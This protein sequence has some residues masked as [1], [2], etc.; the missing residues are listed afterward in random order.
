MNKNT[1]NTILDGWLDFALRESI[2][3]TTLD[4]PSINEFLTVKFEGLSESEDEVLLKLRKESTSLLKKEFKKQ[5]EGASAE[6][7]LFFP[8]IQ[9]VVNNQKVG[10]PL[11]AYKLNTQ[12]E[13]MIDNGSI[14]F[15]PFE[16]TDIHIMKDIFQNELNLPEEE[17][18]AE[19]N[20]L[21]FMNSLSGSN[22]LT[23]EN[24][25]ENF[26]EYI[27]GLTRFKI[28][29][30]AI[31]HEG[32]ITYEYS[33]FSK[34]VKLIRETGLDFSPLSKAYLTA[35]PEVKLNEKIKH[36]YGSFNNEYPLG[37]GQ[38]KVLTAKREN[39]VVPV[40]GAPGTGK[41]T[42]I[43]SV[44]AEHITK[45]AI[46]LLSNSDRD[47]VD[48]S[49]LIM[50]LSSANKAVENIEEGLSNDPFLK[51]RVDF[52]LFLGN[53]EKMSIASIKIDAFLESFERKHFNAQRMKVL[54]REIEELVD[55]MD[56][57][58]IKTKEF[59]KYV[60]EKKEM[61][62]RKEVLGI[63]LR[64]VKIGI[65]ELTV[66]GE[67]KEMDLD[68]LSG[69]VQKME[70]VNQLNTKAI[71]EV[72]S[73]K[74]HL[75][76]ISILSDKI[77]RKIEDLESLP[78]YVRYEGFSEE[79]MSNELSNIEKRK[80]LSIEM[81]NTP[82][83][84]WAIDGSN[85]IH[86]SLT[87][88]IEKVQDI[89]MYKLEFIFKTRNKLLNNFFLKNEKFLTKIGFTRNMFSEERLFDIK[90]FFFKIAELKDDGIY[91]IVDQSDNQED[92]NMARKIFQVV[93]ELSKMEKAL[94]VNQNKI[95]RC[96]QLVKKV[97][98]DSKK[99]GVD[100]RHLDEAKLLM[101]NIVKLQNI[102][103]EL[104]AIEG[105]L[106]E[107]Q[108]RTE[109]S[110]Q[111][112][113]GDIFEVCRKH[114]IKENR[115]LFELSIEYLEQIQLKNKYEVI[116]ALKSFQKIIN[117]NLN[118]AGAVRSEWNGRVSRLYELVSLAFP[119]LTSTVASFSK[120]TSTFHSGFFN[121]I[122][123][124]VSWN[125]YEEPPISLMLS[126]ESGMTKVHSL[127][128]PVYYSKQAIIVGDENQLEP[129]VTISEQEIQENIF[130]FFGSDRMDSMYSPGYVSAYGRSAGQTSSINKLSRG[131]LLDEHRR[132]Q[133]NIANIFKDIVQGSYYDLK[134]QTPVLSGDR[135]AKF[136]GF[137]SQNNIIY[138]VQGQ[139][140]ISNVNRLEV[141]AVDSVLN[142]LEVAGYDLKKDV[143]IITPYKGQAKELM[144]RYKNRVNHSSAPGGTKKIG[145][146]HSFQGVEFEVIIISTV[147]AGDKSA[148]FINGK[149]SL[150]NVSVSRAKDVLIVIGDVAKL[151]ASGGNTA[152]LM[153]K[154]KTNGKMRS[155]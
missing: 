42:L 36:W 7:Y 22:N 154:M 31:I 133:P 149:K 58:Y 69:I 145:T 78:N 114:H 105:P 119:V 18:P 16:G 107:L 139:V 65:E 98:E 113:N 8:I 70:K 34:Q 140:T 96:D 23:F 131:I 75:K 84:K 54:H 26:C 40:E 21:D 48:E 77:E 111:Y 141:N 90:A 2:S 94:K 134:V 85:D 32:K 92:I 135:K 46:H 24:S 59:Q 150:L 51:D 1:F 74:I 14:S 147:I 35:T 76:E 97:E 50:V 122:G 44:I 153:S 112:E 104:N 146:V 33:T 66:P 9:H 100:Y 86:S 28:N 127:F 109:S 67:Y 79:E 68:E 61:S 3:V 138:N 81:E 148:R 106:E 144:A 15:N 91:N 43:L 4:L 5:R 128:P 53:S 126:D 41:T 110:E 95:K 93:R 13:S 20:L 132:C 37:V 64:D 57:K 73:K 115:K 102:E 55:L 49:S 117:G 87:T 72:N 129:I 82:L 108:K 143:G 142:Q 120:M 29:S 80:S 89:P 60:L 71:Q 116:L 101:S 137:G 30:D 99:Y 52:S 121:G 88:L 45:R 6:V 136:E 151:E 83:Y 39:L 62:T 47:N 63:M 25:Y 17:L 124:W 118:D 103:K 38:G 152:T 11:F 56:S 12:K 125:K 27:Q 130:K 155:L 19:R 123:E 10:L